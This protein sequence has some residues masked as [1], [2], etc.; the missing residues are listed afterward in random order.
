MKPHNPNFEIYPSKE[1]SKFWPWTPPCPIKKWFLIKPC[2]AFNLSGKAKLF[3]LYRKRLPWKSGKDRST[4][5]LL[6]CSS[7]ISTKKF[8]S[9]LWT[10]VTTHLSAYSLLTNPGRLLN[11]VLPNTKFIIHFFIR[12]CR[13]VWPS[14]V[15]K[16]RLSSEVF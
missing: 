3:S 12:N 14:K 16:C 9:C 15:F 1:K 4:H 8:S 11:P 7:L 5:K 13:L 10:P 2:G 6:A